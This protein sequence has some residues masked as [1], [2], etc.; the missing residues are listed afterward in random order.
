M[1]IVHI[2][3]MTVRTF[4]YPLTLAIIA[5]TAAYLWMIGRAPYCEC[6]YVKLWHGALMSSQNS[7][8]ILD[9]YTFSHVIHGFAFFG[10]LWF[11]RRWLPFGWRLAIATAVEAAWEIVENS[12]AVINH[13]RTATASLDYFGD[14]VLN[15]VSDIAVMIIGFYVA[16]RLPW[17]ATVALVLIFEAFTIWMIRDGLLF[18]I[19][20]LISPIDALRDWQTE[21]WNGL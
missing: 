5:F 17:W 14:S 12:D 20:M 6:G 18:N 13:Y 15:S 2:D 1:N 19:I 3:R 9:W 11:V 16:A 10:L 21:L 8:H 7:Q 4:A